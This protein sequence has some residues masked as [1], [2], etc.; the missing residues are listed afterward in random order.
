MERA[1]KSGI[2]TFTVDLD[3]GVMVSALAAVNA[4]G[5]IVDPATG[6]IVA[7]ARIAKESREFTN[8]AE[9]MKKGAFGGARRQNTTLVVVATN[10]RLSKPMANKLAQFGSAGVARAISPVWTMYDG[11][12]VVALSIGDKQADI[13][14]LGV[15]A[16]EAVATSI[17]RAVELAPTLGGLPGLKS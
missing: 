16:A 1:M 4:V 8:S 10:A 17:V 15:A 3:G 11:D 2:G 14:V 13:N 5:D 6:K 12:I 9:Q 7:G